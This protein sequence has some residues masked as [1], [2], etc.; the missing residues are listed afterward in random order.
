MDEPASPL[1]LEIGNQYYHVS[2]YVAEWMNERKRLF[3]LAFDRAMGDFLMKK[4]VLV[5]GKTL[6][7]EINGRL[8]WYISAVVNR[9]VM[10]QPLAFPDKFVEEIKL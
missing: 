7:I 10:W 3:E 1:N 2:F 8:Y 9:G 5:P 4:K 6:K